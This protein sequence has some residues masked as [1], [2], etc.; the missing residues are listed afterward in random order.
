MFG[1]SSDFAN[2]DK[3]IDQLQLVSIQPVEKVNKPAGFALCSS[4]REHI[5]INNDAPDYALVDT[6][7]LGDFLQSF[8]CKQ[9]YSYSLL[10]N[11][12]YSKGFA[13]FTTLN[14]SECEF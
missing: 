4:F 9:Y 8:P 3:P 10:L 13:K 2:S 7:L 6:K 14:C 12:V 11:K 1:S 5:P